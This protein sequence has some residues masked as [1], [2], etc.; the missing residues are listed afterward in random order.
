MLVNGKKDNNMKTSVTGYKQNSKDK[1]EPILE[2]LSNNITM[3]GVPHKVVGIS[4]DGTIQ[5]MKPNKNYY[6]PNTQSVTEIP[7]RQNGGYI[8][9]NSKDNTKI[10][11]SYLASL[12]ED[13]QDEILNYMDSLDFNGQRKFLQGGKVVWSKYQ[14]GGTTNMQQVEV[15]DGETIQNN[16]G[17]LYKFTGKKHSEGGIDILAEGGDKIF[18]EHLKVEPE[19]AKAILGK[20]VKKKMSYAD[21]SKKFDTTK[22]SKVLKNPESD[23]Y[24]LETANLKM[25]H[26]DMMLDTIFTAQELNKKKNSKSK[27]QAGGTINLTDPQHITLDQDIKEIH[28]NKWEFAFDRI[29]NRFKSTNRENIVYDPITNTH[30]FRSNSNGWYRPLGRPSKD[31]NPLIVDQSQSFNWN[32]LGFG[33]EG[34]TPSFKRSVP[35]MNVPQNISPELG[36]QYPGI[37]E[38]PSSTVTTGLVLGDQRNWREPLTPKATQVLDIVD[39]NRSSVAPQPVQSLPNKVKQR[40]GNKPITTNDLS[41]KQTK[42][43]PLD[44]LPLT[45]LNQRSVSS[46]NKQFNIGDYKVEIPNSTYQTESKSKPY[47]G[48]SSKLAGTLLDI[49]L[50]ASDKLTVQNPQYR[51]LRK[52]PLF[53]RFVDFDDKEVGRNMALNIQQI[54]NSNLPEEVKQSRIADLTS[55][56]KDYQA[57]IDFGNAQRYEQKIN[58][59]TEKLQNYINANIDQQY[60]DLERYRQKKA[61]VDELRDQ[62]NAQKKSRIVNSVRNYF[63]YVNR[64]NLENKIYAENYKIDP[65]FGGVHFTQGTKDPLKKQES[66]LNQYSQNSKN[67]VPLPN[68]G[69][70]TILNESV[71]IMTDSSGKQETVKLK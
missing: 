30:L 24:Q 40:S 62:F 23:P 17:E 7:I 10:F 5:V 6:Y 8:M 57:K 55:Q 33:T 52:Y 1:N 63:D 71:G 35:T 48:I 37:H 16:E 14:K 28:G 68:G 3:A 65:I 21:L 69:T 54:Q 9:K 44:M 29:S 45:P 38:E 42:V 32:T 20:D 59:D 67:T 31:K 39:P 56:Y 61:R 4:D 66:L 46:N 27:F 36:S 18:S 50:A 19:I 47:L 53:S 41:N 12:H 2:I 64:T 22:W 60:E 13:D 26:N 70:L 34:Q 58:Q 43:N 15:E 51:D 49:G 25:A 11:E